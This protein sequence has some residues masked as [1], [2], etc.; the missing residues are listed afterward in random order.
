MMT[1][2]AA[3]PLALLAALGSFAGASSLDP[4]GGQDEPKV[5]LLCKLSAKNAK[6]LRLRL[7]GT[8]P[9]PDKTVLRIHLNRQAEV[10]AMGKLEL[11][12]T[13]AGGGLVEVHNRKFSFEPA[14]EGPGGYLVH[15]DFTE[16]NQ[17]QSVLEA[18]K[19]KS[20]RKRWTFTFPAWNDELA[21]Q[22]SSRLQDVD[23][24]AGE[25][26]EIIRK[27]E[28]ATVSKLSW[29]AESKNLTK[30]CGALLVRIQRAEAYPLYPAAMSQIHYTIRSIQG[31]SPYFDW[32]SGKFAGGKSYHA[33]N[34][35][36]KTHRQEKYSFENLKRYVEDA[37][38][39]AGREL[40]LWIVKDLRRTG[41][42]M[43]NDLTEAIKT[44][45][46][47]PG[48][49]P[50]SEILPKAAAADLD[51]LEKDLRAGVPEKKDEKKEE[52]KDDKKPADG[53][54]K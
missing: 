11:V 4:R 50:F 41:G 27:F 14:I 46:Q 48:L 1:R 2:F 21:P 23:G 15:V 17:R 44:H 8:A 38:P 53:L 10:W 3:R 29:E 16:D 30:E 13:G 37:V 34:Q 33:D 40:G 12:A 24:L 26:L 39:V 49:A 45:A 54:K 47:H 35:E 36:I 22:L 51:G 43:R 25:A 9:Y 5:E 52:K 42:T 6:V 28:K 32:V 20:G 7:D 18:L 19:G 31:T